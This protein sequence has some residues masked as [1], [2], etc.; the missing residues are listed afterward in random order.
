[1]RKRWGR[2]WDK[3]CAFEIA[4]SLLNSF[5]KRTATDIATSVK[6][7]VKDI[8]LDS[9]ATPVDLDA[10]RSISV[11]IHVCQDRRCSID[12]NVTTSVNLTSRH[13]SR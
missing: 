12:P 5:H 11:G 7:D 6:I 3:Q 10:E 1:M 2:S 9:V 4:G 8:D 13:Q